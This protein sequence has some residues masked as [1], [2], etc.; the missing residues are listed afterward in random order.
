M[1]IAGV[2]ELKLEVTDFDC[3][4]RERDWEKCQLF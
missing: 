3:C 2:G 1:A 4:Y